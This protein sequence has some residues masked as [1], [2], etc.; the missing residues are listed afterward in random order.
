MTAHLARARILIEHGRF[1]TAEQELRQE[2]ALDPNNG[3]AHSLLAVTLIAQTRYEEAIREAQHGVGLDPDS[4]YSYFAMAFALDKGD[5]SDEAL[6]VIQ[7]AIRMDPEKAMYYATL[8]RIHLKK[9]RWQDALTAAEQGLRIDSEDVE[10]TNLRAMALVKLGRKEEA[11]LTIDTALA[12]DPENSFSHANQGWTLLHRGDHEKAMEHFREALR[13][14]PASTWARG[15]IVEALKA[16]NIIY[17]I[18]LQYFLWMS[19]LSSRARWGVVLGAYFAYRVVLSISTTNPN[20]SPYLRPLL[21]LYGAFVFLSWTAG[22]LFNLLLRLNRLGRLSL[23]NDQITASNWVGACIVVALVLFII[24]ILPGNDAIKG[25]LHVAAFEFLIIIVPVSGTSRIPAGKRRII[26]VVYT[27]LLAII[28]I[29]SLALSLS[30]VPSIN[31][32]MV[33]WFGIMLYSWVANAIASIT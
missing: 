19:R 22:P 12:K 15:G 1:N 25:S 31:L 27:V 13:L 26:M 16:R 18:M 20:L 6:S 2:L 4:A 28:G 9:K 11:G 30:G 8:S 21:F 23:T 10:C 14:N 3:R 32:D 33:F 24:G 5:R 17:R 29:V 7:K